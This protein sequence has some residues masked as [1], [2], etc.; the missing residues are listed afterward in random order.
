M[1]GAGDERR[2]HH[3]PAALQQCLAQVQFYLAK[4]GHDRQAVRDHPAA[5]PAVP[6]E[7]TGDRSPAVELN[8]LGVRPDQVSGQA[9]EFTEGPGLLGA[10]YDAPL[11]PID[12][13]GEGDEVK[14]NT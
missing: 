12:L 8:R 2:V 10:P 13:P 9:G 3:N 6:A 11:A 7:D 5:F 14:E 1:N 4:N